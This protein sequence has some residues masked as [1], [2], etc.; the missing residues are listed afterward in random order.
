MELSPERTDITV[1]VGVVKAIPFRAA[2]TPS[3]STYSGWTAHG[4]LVLSNPSP[5]AVE[6][7]ALGD[8]A[9]ELKLD[10]VCKDR[11]P[12]VV[13]AFGARTCRWSAALPDGDT[14]TLELEAVTRG[15]VGGAVASLPVEYGGA[16]VTVRDGKAWVWDQHAG[17]LGVT[18][19][20]RVYDF[21]VELGPYAWCGSEGVFLDS[22]TLY[23]ADTGRRVEARTWLRVKV[24][25]P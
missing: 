10:L 13:P 1:P 9:H 7:I 23:G 21:E 8:R 2:V 4:E 3:G 12:F 25:C 6:V 11:P 17:F 24:P 20:A 16:V 15:E 19:E 14:R 5:L 22:A 18:A